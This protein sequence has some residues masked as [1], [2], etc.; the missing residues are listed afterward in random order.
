MRTALNALKFKITSK[1]I[2][3]IGILLF[4]FCLI[5]ELIFARFVPSINPV[6]VKLD[7]VYP[8]QK[9]GETWKSIDVIEEDQN[10]YICG[11]ARANVTPLKAQIQVRVYENELQPM[12]KAIYYDNIWISDGQIHLLIRSQFWP[13]KYIIEV[14]NGRKTLSVI[15]FEV[16]AK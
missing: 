7:H 14:N 12:Y 13:G 2:G 5:A 11:V 16:A 10:I 4:A 15:S 6:T 1:N 3:Y 8:C 9:D